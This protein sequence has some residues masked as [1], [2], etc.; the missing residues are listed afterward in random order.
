[1]ARGVAG[2]DASTSGFLE[3]AGVLF[4]SDLLRALRRVLATVDGLCEAESIVGVAFPRRSAAP[5]AFKGSG[6]LDCAARSP[7]EEAS[8]LGDM[9]ACLRLAS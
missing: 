2:L 8:R 3:E 7:F 6:V 4:A 9:E 1:M 5:A